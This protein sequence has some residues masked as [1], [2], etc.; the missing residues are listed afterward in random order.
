MVRIIK[1]L[2][3]YVLL[4]ALVYLVVSVAWELPHLWDIHDLV[5]H[6]PKS[7]ALMEQR[8]REYERRGKKPR[9]RR[10]FVPYRSISQ[11]LK[12]AVLVAE[13]GTFFSH[14]GIDYYELRESLIEDIK[15]LSFKR[16]GST[17][18]QQLVKNLYLSTSKTLSRKLA[19]V[20]LT[21]GM[22][23][24]LGKERIFELYLNYIEWGEAIYGCE[25]AAQ[26]Y[27]KRSCGGLTPGRAVRLAAIIINPRRYGPQSGSRRIGKRLKI[28][29]RRMR[30]AGY[31]TEEEFRAL[32]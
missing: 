31:L 17:I 18:T 11:H 19:E 24:Q 16:G 3:K 10:R 13:D 7:T 8:A 12:H 30:S 6:N 14:G 15:S 25:A 4:A 23:W 22:E 21:K 26:V 20:I 32:P 1:K 2:I 5:K 29:A 9:A 28:I 27:F